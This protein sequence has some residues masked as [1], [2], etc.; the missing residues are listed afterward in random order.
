MNNNDTAEIQ[1]DDDTFDA[2]A[3]YERIQDYTAQIKS[4]TDIIP[5]VGVLLESGLGS[6]LDGIGSVN[7]TIKYPSLDGFPVPAVDGHEGNFVLVTWAESRSSSCRAGCICMKD[8][9]RRKSCFLSGSCMN[10]K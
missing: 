2:E 5:E 1:I 9:L 7:S 3:Y 6:F 4:Q 10:S 8:T